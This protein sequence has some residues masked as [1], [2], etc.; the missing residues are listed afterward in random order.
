VNCC[1]APLAIEALAGVTAID[2]SAG[3]P[4][5]L[6]A[7][8]ATMASPALEPATTLLIPIDA[9]LTPATKVTLTTA[10]TP[11]A[12]VL[13]FIPE[14]KQEYAPDAE[15]QVSV[16]EALVVAAPALAE[17]EVTEL[18]E[19]VRVHCKV[20]GWL[21]DGDAKFTF[22]VVPP[23][24]PGP[25]VSESTCPKAGSDDAIKAIAITGITPAPLKE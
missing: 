22:S 18:A 14:T 16:L 7:P 25:R 3:A 24:V 17:M 12:I 23:P 21:P 19:N 20:D 10:T 13:A 1:V 4:T 2:A 6:P 15:K 11:F 8:D 9:L 5:V